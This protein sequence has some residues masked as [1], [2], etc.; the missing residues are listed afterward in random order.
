MLGEAPVARVKFIR[1]LGTVDARQMKHK[2]R[3]GGVFRQKLFWRVDVE[4][5]Q[6]VIAAI[7]KLGDKVFSH[8]SARAGNEQR[9][10]L[11]FQARPAPL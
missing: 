6:V 11:I 4:Q 1:I 3:P 2:V 10:F 7:A 5:Q 8:K 9:F